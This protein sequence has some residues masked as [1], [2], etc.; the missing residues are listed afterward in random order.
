MA[1]PRVVGGMAVAYT[2]AS[3]L[4]LLVLRCC[5][6]LQC[7]EP[8]ASSAQHTQSATI[9]RTESV[10]RSLVYLCVCMMCVCVFCLLSV[11]FCSVLSYPILSCPL[12]KLV[13]VQTNSGDQHMW[14]HWPHTDTTPLSLSHSPSL[15]SS[16]IS[17]AFCCLSL[18]FYQLNNLLLYLLP[19]P[20]STQ[21]PSPSPLSPYCTHQT[22][23]QHCCCSVDDFSLSHYFSLVSFQLCPSLVQAQV[24]T[25][26]LSI[27]ALVCLYY[28]SVIYIHICCAS[29]WLM[30][31][32]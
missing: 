12:N 9:A 11:L 27:S 17:S 6:W 2:R 10:D 22:Q 20:S 25:N 1:W 7:L 21:P 32:L 29:L 5:C 15:L 3:T 13:S 23:Q 26:W 18:S 19:Q 30:S 24:T 28:N 16:P 31:K 14:P 4:R 8:R